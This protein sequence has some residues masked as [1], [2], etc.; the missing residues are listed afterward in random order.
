MRRIGAHSHT[1]HSRY[2][3]RPCV[4]RKMVFRS[5]PSLRTTG[6]SA[7]RSFLL[8]LETVRVPPMPTRARG[9]PSDGPLARLTRLGCDGIC[10]CG[11]WTFICAAAGGTFLPGGL[12]PAVG[13]IFQNPNLGETLRKIGAGG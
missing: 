6:T 10:Q 9:R 3:P 8:R 13:Q 12:A 4:W 11:M 7:R 5:R 1:G 2:L